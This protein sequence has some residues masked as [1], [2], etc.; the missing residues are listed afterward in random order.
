MQIMNKNKDTYA[1]RYVTLDYALRTIELICMIVT[2]V[3]NFVSL[4]LAKTCNGMWQRYQIIGKKRRKK[5]NGRNR[6]G[7]IPL[8]PAAEVSM[9]E[10]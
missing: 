10:Q 7:E 2:L 3:Y 8:L 6:Q 1:P 4:G 9:I 5:D